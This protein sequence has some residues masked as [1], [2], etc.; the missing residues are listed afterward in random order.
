MGSTNGPGH[1]LSALCSRFRSRPPTPPSRW[2]LTAALMCVQDA[3]N[4]GLEV[5][6]GADGYPVI[7]KMYRNGVVL[8]PQ[9]AFI[10]TWAITSKLSRRC[11][12]LSCL[13]LA[14]REHHQQPAVSRRS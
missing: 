9:V 11:L 2:M 7:V 6:Q 5:E 13:L 1:R 12:T 4:L 8:N 3:S 10:Q 14:G